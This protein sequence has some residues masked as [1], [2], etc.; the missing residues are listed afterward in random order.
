M[1]LITY[2]FHYL[3]FENLYSEEELKII[4]EEIDTLNLTNE[5]FLPPEKTGSVEIDIGTK[6]KIL[7]TNSGIWLDSDQSN[8]S[9]VN[10][11]D[12]FKKLYKPF[13]INHPSSWFFKNI[14][15]NVDT[16]LL[17]Y[18][19][20]GDYYL[21]HNDDSYVTACTWLY[22]EP[23]QFLGGEFLFPDYDIKIPCKNNSCIVFP[24]NIWH[25]VNKVYISDSYKNKGFGRYCVSQFISVHLG[26]PN[27]PH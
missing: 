25:S 3:Y 17:S 20:D 11:K 4:W 14:N 27:E 23:K 18:Y 9:L 26:Q 12:I 24:S 22:K 5:L 13:Y 15:F 1:T 19:D 21:R 2:P 16:I 6:T 8:S 10:L 7:K